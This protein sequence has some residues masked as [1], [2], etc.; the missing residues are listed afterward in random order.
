MRT[1]KQRNFYPDVK[2]YVYLTWLAAGVIVL[3]FFFGFILPY[4]IFMEEPKN[5][6]EFGDSFGSITSLFSGLGTIAIAY[7]IFLQIRNQQDEKLQARFSLYNSL[8][9]EIKADINSIVIHDFHGANAVHELVNIIRE[10]DAHG[11]DAWRLL[12][13]QL[14]M[15]NTSFAALVTLIKDQSNDLPETEREILLTKVKQID[16]TY[17]RDLNRVIIKLQ[18]A[19]DFKDFHTFSKLA[20][21]SRNVYRVTNKLYS[22]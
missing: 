5:G 22:A 8:L 17:L 6:G 7:T 3:W 10:K 12:V 2:M 15:I 14:Y 19:P 9:N 16:F 4:L 1:A 11:L 20:A 18:D 21:S 13:Q